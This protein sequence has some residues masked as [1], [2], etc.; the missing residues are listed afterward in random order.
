MQFHS[1]WATQCFFFLIMFYAI[2]CVFIFIMFML[3]MVVFDISVYV[4]QNLGDNPQHIGV[5]LCVYLCFSIDVLGY[6]HSFFILMPAFASILLTLLLSLKYFKYMLII[7]FLL[8]ISIVDFQVCPPCW[9]TMT[10]C[11][12]CV[13]ICPTC[14]F[15]QYYLQTSFFSI[16]FHLNC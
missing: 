16:C 13:G 4:N 14:Q 1:N 7:H 9:F 11:L 2:Q 3:H 8:R 10:L 5:Y 15:P 12:S 6:S